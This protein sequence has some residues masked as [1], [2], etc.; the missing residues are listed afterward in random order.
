MIYY[1]LVLVLFTIASVCTA[2]NSAD[3]PLC[4][5]ALTKSATYLNPKAPR[6]KRVKD[7]LSRMCWD[8]KVTQLGGVGGILGQNNTLDV[9]DY[10]KKARLHNGTICK[11]FAPKTSLQRLTSP[12]SYLNYAE[13]AVP[14]LSDL[15]VASKKEHRLG[16]PCV[17]IADAVNGP[18]FRG[19]TL[20]PSTLSMAMSWNLPL[21]T[22]VA[23]VLRDEL[24]A[25]GVNWVLSPEV[26]V[27]RDPRNGRV[28]EMYGEDP[29]MNGEYA[30]AYISTMQEEDS[31]G[32]MK[33]ATTIKHYLY[34]TST[35]GINQAS[36]L[37]GV[38]H[39]YNTLALPYI[40]V[41]KKVA[42]ASVMPS[43]STIDGIPAHSN[44]YLLQD[45]LR[46]QF[47]YDGVIVSDADAIAMLYLTH[48]TA[49]NLNDAGI[50]SLAAGVQLELA[51]GF[52]TAFESLTGNQAVEGVARNVN[53][54][55]SRILN[56][57]FKL[58]LF[59]K[60]LEADAKALKSLRS[61]KHTK[62]NN[63][64]LDAI[65]T[66]FG[67][68]NVHHVRG[69]DTIDTDDTEIDT[70]VAAA[71]N[72][73]LAIVALG[74]I[75]V[76]WE[77]SLVGDRTDGEGNTHASLKLPGRQ[78]ELLEAITATGVPTILV[79]TGGQ[80]FEL[81]GAAQDAQ[82]ILHGFHSGEETGRA[83]VDI[84]TG[85]VNP[86]GKLT[87][88][89]PARSEVNPVY[90][91]RE[92]SD[93]QSAG[94]IQFPYLEKNY[95]YS[96]GYGLSF[97]KFEF[98][99]ARLDKPAYGP[100]DSVK[101]AV[102]VSNTG[103][104]DGKEVVQ[105]YFKQKVAPLSLPVKRLVGFSKVL[106]SAGSSKTVEIIIPV[107]DLGYWLDGRYRVDVGTYEFFVGNSS[108]DSSLS[109]ALTAVVA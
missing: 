108:A 3:G 34:C 52:P 99:D 65:K 56:L 11:L 49:A 30:A 95:I 38:N 92:Q 36:M 22:E 7:L 44:S 13:D 48:K 40:N 50:K 103:K 21:Y 31:N 57:K 10:R 9:Q 29:W 75:A 59:D 73:G 2:D 1:L 69:V 27:A 105:V 81:H 15:I 76:G 96:F 89:F 58:G 51:I 5:K 67:A 46:Q 33:V 37:G 32:F 104:V 66:E 26:D 70:A 25:C 109:K 39:I 97:T 100:K 83:L 78:E 102:K 106:V 17:H 85:R 94:A 20:F 12:G 71:K 42:P 88:T 80:A 6:D 68:E 84:I 72:A 82:A 35:G 93:W 79:L 91:N 74:S 43:Y 64:L 107:Q 61:K 55:V 23:E 98:S 8:E 19:T 101:V 47:G 24:M 4:S 62:V 16:I 86:S 45:I 63:T 60:T 28:G 77:D 41:M 90:Y 53:E 14:V 87:I 54:A 18:T